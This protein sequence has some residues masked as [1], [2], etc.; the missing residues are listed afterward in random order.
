MTHSVFLRLRVARS[1][2]GGSTQQVADAASKEMQKQGSLPR[3]A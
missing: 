3:G 2:S 1:D